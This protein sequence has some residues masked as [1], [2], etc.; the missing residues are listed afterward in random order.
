MIFSSENLIS[1]NKDSCGLGVADAA[2]VVANDEVADLVSPEVS[3]WATRAMFLIAV[4][5]DCGSLSIALCEVRG[6]MGPAKEECCS[7]SA[8]RARLS[9][10]EEHCK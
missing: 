6:E 2:T 8:S 9:M 5:G 7:R 1:F 10:N 4:S 3:V